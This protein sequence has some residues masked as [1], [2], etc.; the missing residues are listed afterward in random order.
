ML[1]Y[2]IPNTVSTQCQVEAKS[3]HP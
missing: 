3:S 1:T 2:G